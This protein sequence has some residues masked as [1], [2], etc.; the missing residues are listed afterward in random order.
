LG[1]RFSKW[2]QHIC[3]ML[4]DAIACYRT[5]GFSVVSGTADANAK[6]DIGR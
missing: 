5:P 1:D 4:Q 6:I 2:G 3:S